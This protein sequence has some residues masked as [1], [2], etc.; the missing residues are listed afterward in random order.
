VADVM[1]RLIDELDFEVVAVTDETAI[2]VQAVYRKW[3]RGFHRAALKFGD[4]FA[5]DVARERGCRLL[6]IGGDFAQ[7]DITS[8]L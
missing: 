8:V 3:G 5:Y 7:T 1:A 6:Y 4:C 2:R